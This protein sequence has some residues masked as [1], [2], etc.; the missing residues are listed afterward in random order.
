MGSRRFCISRGE[1]KM[2]TFPLHS[3]DDPESDRI[4]E[5]LPP[6]VDAH[7]HLFP[8]NLFQAIWSWFD[9]FA[10]S[11]RYRIPSSSIVE[12]LLSRGVERI[13]ALH[14]AHRPG[15]ARHLNAYM[16]A[17]CRDNPRVIGTATVFPGEEGASAILEEAFKSGLAGVK[18]H[19]HVQGFFMDTAA[20]HE[21][22]AT[23]QAFDKPLVMHVGREPRNPYVEYVE[24]PYTTCRAD[25]LEPVLRDYPRLRVCVPHLGADEFGSYKHMLERYDNL[26][27][28]T[29]MILADYLP[30]TD[31]P[32]L[33][34]IRPDRV[35][36]GTDFPNIP[37]AWDREL[38]NLSKLGLSDAV[39][40]R[41]LGSNANDLFGVRA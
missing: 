29:A 9:R 33:W 31:I 11:I 14:Y 36:Y 25:K 22:Y 3:M 32:S 13:V 16:A 15:L 38:K 24:D 8:D 2:L 19:A 23:C 1:F 40:E 34:E 12:F 5:G 17:V 26:W 20:M 18:L 21:I 39:L 6:V 41:I 10:W 37:Y 28:D 30:V 27:V 35:M 4:P 7:V